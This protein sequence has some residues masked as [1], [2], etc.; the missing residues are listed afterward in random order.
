M[1]RALETPP[2][3]YEHYRSKQR[4]PQRAPPADIGNG[5]DLNGPL[6][7]EFLG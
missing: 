4:S 2:E 1:R 5:D 7:A 6:N 3:S